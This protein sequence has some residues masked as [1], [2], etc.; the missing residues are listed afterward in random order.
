M[1]DLYDSARFATMRAPENAAVF[2]GGWWW[3]ARPD[4]CA[5]CQALH[6]EVF[7]VGT[8]PHRHHQCR[9]IIVPYTAAAPPPPHR[10]ADDIAAQ[11]PASWPRLDTRE[12]YRRLVGL[13]ENRRWRPSHTMRHPDRVA[14]H[15]TWAAGP[16]P[17][18]PAPMGKQGKPAR[19]PR[20]TLAVDRDGWT[21]Y[22]REVNG[23]PMSAAAR[24]E[25]AAAKRAEADALRRRVDT[26]TRDNERIAADL[27][28]NEARPGRDYEANRTRLGFEKWQNDNELA[29]LKV[30]AT[31]LENAAKLI[32]DHGYD[33]VVVS[34][35]K[36]WADRHAVV[37]GDG[38]TVK[39]NR[40]DAGIVDDADALRHA[41]W[42]AE[43]ICAA[44]DRLPPHLRDRVNTGALSLDVNGGAIGLGGNVQAWAFFG[45]EDAPRLGANPRFL[46][47]DKPEPTYGDLTHEGHARHW[48]S[49]G[50][51]VIGGAESV[52]VHEFGH[53]LDTGSHAEAEAR[54]DRVGGSAAVEYAVSRY[55]AKDGREMV[56]ELFAD[57]IAGTVRH[58][59]NGYLQR[60]IDDMGWER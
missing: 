47:P 25:A 22:A 50:R 13:R 42:H 20:P 53:V 35:A 3:R 6:G 21:A 37:S 15:P 11:L 56:A 52:W 23:P 57:F 1:A 46:H 8:D 7:D 51:A 9:C 31:Q 38:W 40:A 32:D 60:I 59:A 26:L 30:R 16:K 28:R 2:S 27:A 12:D 4:A 44:L 10:S 19:T 24:A 45:T 54:L 55:G 29:G 18:P 58:D 36:E 39:I 17:R 34:A 33:P 41:A 43:R 14:G 49:D 48:H 5:L